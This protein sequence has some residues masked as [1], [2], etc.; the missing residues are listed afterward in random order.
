MGTE[1]CSSYCIFRSSREGYC[2]SL[3]KNKIKFLQAKS[4]NGYCQFPALGCDLVRGRDMQRSR[5]GSEVATWSA[6]VRQ[7]RRRD[8]DLMSRHGRQCGRS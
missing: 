7:K 4:W 1:Q 3:K 2:R 5:P 6:L 8:M